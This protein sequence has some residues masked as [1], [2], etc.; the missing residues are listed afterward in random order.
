M[1]AEVWRARSESPLF[2]CKQYAQGLEKLYRI[3][4]NRFA[5]GEKPDHVS[6][7]NVDWKIFQVKTSLYFSLSSSI[8][9]FMEKASSDISL[10]CFT[11]L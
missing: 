2:D 9:V 6:A 4:W 7:Q 1:R 8:K 11:F 5:N 3:M 10:R